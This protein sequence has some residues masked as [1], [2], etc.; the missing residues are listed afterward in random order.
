MIKAIIFD[1]FGVLASD[2]WLPFREK[3]FSDNPDLLE[4]AIASNKRMDAGLHT[5]EDFLRE[6]ADLSEV[7]LNETRALI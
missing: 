3:Y 7:P 1:C 5:Y 6:I 2:G 4:K